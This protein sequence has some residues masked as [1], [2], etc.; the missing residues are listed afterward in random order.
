MTLSK[1]ALREN[2]RNLPER[3][4]DPGT[5]GNSAF[6]E[7]E[8][9]RPWRGPVLDSATA[10]NSS[11]RPKSH[12]TRVL[13][14]AILLI[15]LHQ[16]F[17]SLI[18]ERPLPGEDP[19]WPYWMHRICRRRR[20]ASLTL[21]WAWALV[22]DSRE[23]PLGQLFPWFSLRRMKA[24][25]RISQRRSGAARNGRARLLKS[26]G[27]RAPFMALGFSPSP[28][29]PSPARPG[30]FSCAGRPTGERRLGCTSWSLT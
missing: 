19:A 22:R 9:V 18:L 23:T 28:S 6:F 1:P 7:G 14:L 30:S 13:H 8:A 26:N 25:R 16:L 21:F 10:P 5:F 4:D 29:S 3:L 12:V 20:R 2:G 24:I 15:V 27:R 17:G 11:K